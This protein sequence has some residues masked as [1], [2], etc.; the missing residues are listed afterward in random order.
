M[1]SFAKRLLVP[2]VVL[3]GVVALMRDA[4]ADLSPKVIKALKGQLIVS[5]GPVEQGASDKDTVA[6]YKAARKKEIKGEANADDVQTWNFH[7]T[8][9]LK[10]KG[11]T[12]LTMQF[13]VD[14][15]LAGD[16]RLEGVD[17]SLTVLEGDISITEDDGPSRGKKY[18]LKLV[19]DSKGKDVL[20]ATTTL[21]ME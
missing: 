2:A 17:A 5:D 6:A 16:R 1:T 21:T 11:F 12:S 13:L 3:L 9:F 10:K 15:K 19:G 20:L 7:Y 4:Q 8:A 14:G 18:T